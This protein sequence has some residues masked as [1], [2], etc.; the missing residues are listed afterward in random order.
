MNVVHLLLEGTVEQCESC[1]FSE[2]LPASL[3]VL[4]H[5]FSFVGCDLFLLDSESGLQAESKKCVD[6]CCYFLMAQMEL[7][8][9]VLEGIESDRAQGLE[10]SIVEVHNGPAVGA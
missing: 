2:F 1:H 5:C 8:A 4:F 6:V 10:G 9:L 3:A 7:F